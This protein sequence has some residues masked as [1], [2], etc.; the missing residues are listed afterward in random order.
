MYSA[1]FFIH[2]V[3]NIVP[4]STIQLPALFWYTE[5]SLTQIHNTIFMQPYENKL[6]CKVKYLKYIRSGNFLII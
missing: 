6:F 2:K 3:S 4:V 5:E 1:V